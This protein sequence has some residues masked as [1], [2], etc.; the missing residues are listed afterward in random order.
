MARVVTFGEI[1]M[2]LAAPHQQ[3]IIQSTAFDITYAGGEANVAVSLA[4]FGHE[5]AYVTVLPVNLLGD[6]ALA[7]LRYY[8]VDTSAVV[9]SR[10][11]RLGLYFIEA[12]ASQRASLVLYDRAGSSVA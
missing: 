11:G 4:A 7:A 3:R 6:A 2:R 12:G 1:M 8:G 10:E 9:R 5:A